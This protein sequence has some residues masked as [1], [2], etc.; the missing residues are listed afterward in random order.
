LIDLAFVPTPRVIAY[1]E[2][3]KGLLKGRCY[4]LMEQLEGQLLPDYLETNRESPERLA[5]VARSFRDLWQALDRLRA[6]HGD[7]KATNLIVDPAGVVHLFDLDAFRF[8]LSPRVFARGRRKDYKRFMQ[9]W[10][11]TPEFKRLFL[12]ELSVDSV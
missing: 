9:N 3:K 1:S 4:L 5:T 6:A 12:N 8:G 7:L 11:N 10:Q 2:E